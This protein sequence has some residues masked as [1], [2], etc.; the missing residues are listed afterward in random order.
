MLRKLAGGELVDPAEADRASDV[1]MRYRQ[2]HA[3]ALTKATMGL[4]SRVNTAGYPVLVS[5]RLKERATIMHKLE[6]YP[7]MQLVACVVSS[8]PA[9]S[10][11]FLLGDAVSRAALRCGR[12][13]RVYRSTRRRGVSVPGRRLGAV[14]VDEPVGARI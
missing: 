12:S 14:R 8:F 10:S 1:L 11:W 6:R 3:E 13:R 4:R 2:E 9:R 7:R 5:Q